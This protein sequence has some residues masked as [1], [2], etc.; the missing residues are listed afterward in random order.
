MQVT[1][2]LESEITAKEFIETVQSSVI[3]SVTDAPPETRIKRPDD[4]IELTKV[5]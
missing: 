4:E 2:F 3:T 5:K 1:K